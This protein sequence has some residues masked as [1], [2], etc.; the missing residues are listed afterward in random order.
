[1]PDPTAGTPRTEAGKMVAAAIK[2]GSLNLWAF[3]EEGH[4]LIDEA[5]ARIEAEASGTGLDVERLA[6]AIQSIATAKGSKYV[7]PRDAGDVA[8]EYAALSP[9]P[10][11]PETE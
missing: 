1:M 6:R 10:V 8:A 5:I 3:D 4:V 9:V 7:Y 2:G 11:P